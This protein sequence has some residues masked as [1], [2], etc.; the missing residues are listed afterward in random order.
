[1]VVGSG[2]RAVGARV[3]WYRCGMQWVCVVVCRV[4]RVVGRVWCPTLWFL[5]KRLKVDSTRQTNGAHKSATAREGGGGHVRKRVG[6][7]E[8][9]RKECDV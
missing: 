5:V 4:C 3:L 2:W 1:M 7:V 8:E 9:T 6:R